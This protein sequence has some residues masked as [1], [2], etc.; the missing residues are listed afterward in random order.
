[1][2]TKRPVGRPPVDFPPGW[3][4]SKNPA[5][6]RPT[7]LYRKWQSMKARCYQTSHPANAYYRA[8]GITVCHEWINDFQLFAADMGEPAP[9][10]TLERIDNSKGYS[11]TNCRWATWKEQANNRE[12]GGHKTI[13]PD[14]LRQVCFR[15]GLPY[16]RVYQRLRAG[17]S[18]RDALTLDP[19]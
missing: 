13:K 5:T 4:R 10:L 3:H 6:G 18:M 19:L 11:P 17:W 8:K 7:L 16:H 14:S 15:A 2:L 9:G 12:Q 1:M